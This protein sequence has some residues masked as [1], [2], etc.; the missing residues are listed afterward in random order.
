[1]DCMNI[2]EKNREKIIKQFEKKLGKF[3]EVDRDSE[4]D[5]GSGTNTAVYYFE[6][7][8]KYIK[9]T[10][11]YNSYGDVLYSNLEEVHLVLKTII[12]YESC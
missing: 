9:Y 3:K 10:G 2:S 11:S 8:D 12:A 6:K 4:Y 7:Y 5:Y 1:M